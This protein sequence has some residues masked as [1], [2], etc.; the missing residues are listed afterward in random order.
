MPSSTGGNFFSSNNYYYTP[1]ISLAPWIYTVNKLVTSPDP[2]PSA[3]EKD[4]VSID[5]EAFLGNAHHQL[6]MWAHIVSCL[7]TQLLQCSNWRSDWNQDC[8]VST[9]KKSCNRTTTPFFP[10]RGGEVWGRHYKYDMYP[11]YLPASVVLLLDCLYS[12]SWEIAR[13]KAKN[14]RVSYK[15]ESLKSNFHQWGLEICYDNYRVARCAQCHTVNLKSRKSILL[16]PMTW[17]EIFTSEYGSHGNAYGLQI[18]CTSPFNSRD[19]TR[20]WSIENQ[21]KDTCIVK[22]DLQCFCIYWFS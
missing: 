1:R 3:R 19:I 16:I 11:I 18:D 5:H 20:C 8:W 12:I 13:N 2:T 10:C 9:Y 15:M 4:L 7:A 17:K 22:S 21:R 14:V 6:A